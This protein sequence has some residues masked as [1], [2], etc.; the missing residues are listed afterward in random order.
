MAIIIRSS[1]RVAE[2]ESGFTSE[3]ANNQG[4]FMTLEGPMI[5]LAVVVLAVYHPGYA[6]DNE[7]AAA[8]WSFRSDK[9][10]GTYS[11]CSG[12]SEG[13]SMDS[14]IGSYV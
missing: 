1:F 11:L 3:V 9:K 5:M 12:K 4:L 8:S 14:R 6:F 2:L 13:G 10:A 7:W